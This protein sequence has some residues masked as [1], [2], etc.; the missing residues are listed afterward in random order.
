MAYIDVVN[1]EGDLVQSGMGLR[2]PRKK[3]A[4]EILPKLEKFGVGLLVK[5]DGTVV[6]DDDDVD[7]PCVYRLI[8]LQRTQFINPSSSSTSG[9][10]D[11]SSL[12]LNPHIP[13]HS[14]PF[15]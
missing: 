1:P 4:A 7:T 13:I 5:E 14:I 8:P 10:L 12:D 9:P 6:D 11:S 15:S 2:F 3:T